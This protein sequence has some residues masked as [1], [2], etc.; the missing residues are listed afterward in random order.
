MQ[1]MKKTNGQLYK[2][3]FEN[4]INGFAHCHAIYNDAGKMIDWVYVLV[5]ASFEE[6]TGLHNAQ[7]KR[8]SEVIPN[9]L[10]EDADLFS[11]YERVAKGGGQER[12]EQYLKTLGIWF[13]VSVYSVEADTFSVVFENITDQKHHDFKLAEANEEVLMA[14]VRSSESRNKETGD[15]AVRVTKLAVQMAE[16][17]GITG[18]ALMNIRRGALL[19][20]VGKISIPDNILLKEGRL[21]DDEYAIMKRHSQFA[22]D[23]LYPIKYL[24][25]AIDI[26]YCHHEKWDGT[27]YPRGL[28]GKEIPLAARLFSIVD[29]WDALTNDRPYRKAWAEGVVIEHIKQRSGKNF[30]PALVETFLSIIGNHHPQDT[31]RYE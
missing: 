15:H 31:L 2:S 7:G 13:D 11:R 16:V 4:M 14:F 1:N 30:D 9:L 10:I 12:F 22:F 25:P 3:L 5:N 27:G 23:V 18:E 6:Q 29:V 26:P 17:V 20:D 21:T 19:H 24:R 8:V 28:K